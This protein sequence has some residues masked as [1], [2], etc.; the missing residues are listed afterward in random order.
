[1]GKLEA[2]SDDRRKGEESRGTTCLYMSRRG[3]AVVVMVERYPLFCLMFFCLMFFY[4]MLFYLI[5]FYLM[6]FCLMFS[7]LM[8][9]VA[10]HPPQ[11][12][13]KG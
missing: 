4:L 13:G 6:F 5:F 7:I 8:C 11:M 10:D 12:W 9:E 1:M 2:G 3:K